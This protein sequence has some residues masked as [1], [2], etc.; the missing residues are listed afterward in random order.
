M[1]V[2]INL[3]ILIIELGLIAGA[4]W[5][6]Y[7][8]PMVF[9][10]V[11]TL[12]IFSL[13][14]SLEWARLAYELRF[15]VEGEGNRRLRS[16]MMAIVASTESIMKALLSGSVA[17]LTFSGMDHQRL[18]VTA[19]LFAGTTFLGTSALRRLS[20]SFSVRPTRWGYFRLAV[21]LGLA[22]SLATQVL[23]GLGLIETKSLSE[24]A[25]TIV[26]ELPDHPSLALVSDFIFNV[27]QAL[28]A[29]IRAFL[30][31]LVDPSYATVLGIV[32]SLNVLTGLV[33]AIYAVLIAEIV[34]RL[35]DALLPAGK[36]ARTVR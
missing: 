4:A 22:F 13:G 35:E 17:L 6:A 10:G 7:H 20:R 15:Y 27:R 33:I 8:W 34:R 3:V 32:I 16:V 5:L 25:Q 36:A 31:R 18:L 9:A 23:V 12:L 30:L 1:R 26:F 24:I 2:L 11:T 28:D 29:L 19:I 21:P 14:W